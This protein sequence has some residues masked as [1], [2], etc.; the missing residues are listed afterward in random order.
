MRLTDPEIATIRDAAAAVFGLTA[1]VRLFGSRLDD[2]LSD[3]DIDLFIEVDR[4]H[5]SVG[6][7]SWFRERVADALGADTWLD[8][9]VHERGRPLRPIE[10]LAAATGVTLGPGT[11]D[12]KQRSTTEDMTRLASELVAEALAMTDRNLEQLL[13]LQPIVGDLLPMSAAGMQDMPRERLVQIDAFLKQ[14][15]N[16]QDIVQRRLFRAVLMAE[17]ESIRG[18]PVA[19]IADQ[20]QARGALSS[21]A[22]WKAL[23]EPRNRL[24]HDYPLDP[25]IQASRINAVADAVPVLVDTVDAVKRYVDRQ[26]LLTLIV[27]VPD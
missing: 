10:R 15:E 5:G 18:Q 22:E 27:G 9:L 4:G 25:D 11:A 1:Q 8:V 6:T 21:A 17:G 19:E 14:F 16:A 26:G 20:L 23:A 24:I 7:E 13:W 2:T 12:A 3:E